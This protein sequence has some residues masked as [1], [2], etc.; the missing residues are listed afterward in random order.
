VNLQLRQPKQRIVAWARAR[1]R[2]SGF[3]FERLPP[4]DAPGLEACL[5]DQLAAL[6]AGA[7]VLY[8]GVSRLVLEHLRAAG[9]SWT[10][11][12]PASGILGLAIVDLAPGEAFAW[13]RLTALLGESGRLLV[14]FPATGAA[15]LPGISAEW[16]RLG[17]R[18]IDVPEYPRNARPLEA[19]ERIAVLLAP[20]NTPTPNGPAAKRVDEL[21]TWLGGPLAGWTPARRLAG[22][23][24]GGAWDAVLNPG[25]LP[26]PEGTLLLCRVEDATWTEMR[27]DEAVFMRR[28]PPR[29]LDLDPSGTV[30]STRPAIW[31]E[32]PPA[33]THRLEDFRLFTHAGR[34]LS[35]HSI[36][37]LPG[38]T[39]P[40]HPVEPDQLETRVGFS[41]LD[42]LRAEL[43][44]LGEPRLP[45]TLGRTEKN[46]V[47]FS[48]DG[49][50]YL[51][52]SPA[53]YRLYR[54]TDWERLEFSAQLEADWILPGSSPDLPPLRNSINPVPYDEDLWLHIVH[55]VYDGKRYAFWPVL[56]SR[57]TLRPV[58]STR[59]P[60]ACGAWSGGDGLLYLSAA[61]AGSEFIEL[62]SGLED[63][64]TGLTR[65]SRRT[66]D[67]AWCEV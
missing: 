40:G 6:P 30:R 50:L 48:R 22:P 11:D 8:H 42:P 66:L 49:E 20:A 46:W 18:I 44:F 29:L 51:L 33:S 1:L 3:S 60:I 31:T 17:W 37:R 23:T 27:R 4:N 45:R 2:K 9:V 67:A 43:R 56:I 14:R 53:P 55:R 58:R 15:L 5:R 25:A 21:R 52:Y 19:I 63:C 54:C 61:V 13:S 7:A 65:V 24:A 59:Q 57:Q 28:C 36:L 64:A 10:P 47:C 39:R 16:E 26:R 32:A 41:V 34:I 38:P 12:L 35:N 62:Y